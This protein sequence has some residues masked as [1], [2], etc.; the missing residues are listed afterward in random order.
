MM[1]C[2][3]AVDAPAA[4]EY[5]NGSYANGEANQETNCTE[6]PTAVPTN[7]PG[8]RHRPLSI[9]FPRSHQRRYSADLCRCSPS[10]VI[11][12]KKNLKEPDPPRRAVS[13]LTPQSVP[14]NP[15]KRYSCPPFAVF[16]VKTRPFASS[17]SSSSPTSSNS[18]SCSS[19]PPAVQTSTI[20]G[21]DPLGWKLRPKSSSPSPRANRLSLQIPLPVIRRE[22]PASTSPFN[23]D[24]SAK[25][26]APLPPQPTRRRHSDSSAFLKN[27]QPLVTLEE[28]RNAT[29]KE[30]PPVPEKTVT[31]R[32]IAQLM[33]RSHLRKEIIY[34]RVVK[35]KRETEDTSSMSVQNTGGLRDDTSCSEV[36]STP[37]FPG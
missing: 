36:R 7:A 31:T 10:P 24:P 28:L 34:S 20:T 11:T 9:S 35:T 27:S 14:R 8:P 13:L 32:Q 29:G 4:P 6:T 25:T 26:R 5:A 1:K 2:P 15:S 21:P 30:P 33:A 12:V 23:P 3:A 18:S 37:R 16:S 17:S 19:P 22:L